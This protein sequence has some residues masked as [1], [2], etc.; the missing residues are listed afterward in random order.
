[1]LVMFWLLLQPVNW[2]KAYTEY[3][4]YFRK[5]RNHC[6]RSSVLQTRL[7]SMSSVNTNT[8]TGTSAVFDEKDFISWQNESVRYVEI[9]R[10]TTV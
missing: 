7:K 2:V 9:D 3:F 6:Q 8:D 4:V 1:M 10:V 5:I